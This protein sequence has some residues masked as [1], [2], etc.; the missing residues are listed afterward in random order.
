MLSLSNWDIMDIYGNIITSEEREKIIQ[1]VHELPVMKFQDD[2]THIVWNNPITIIQWETG[3]WKTTQVPQ[4][5]EKFW[6]IIT[7]EPRVI[8]AISVADRVSR[9]IMAKT[10]DRNYS[11]GMKVWY[12]TGQQVSSEH[13][14]KISFHTDGLEA[15]RQWISWIYSDV[16]I[17]DEVHWYSIPTEMIASNIRNYML[18]TK[19]KL[20]LV[21]MSAT[22][23]PYILQ[24]YFKQVSSDIPVIKIPGR[25]H[26]VEKHFL[27]NSDYVKTV[28]NHYKEK[29]N[30]LLFVE[31][32]KEIEWAIMSLKRQLWES[33]LIFPLHSELSIEEQVKLLK[34]EHDDPIIVVSTN[35]AEESITLEYIDAVVDIGKEKTLFVNNYGIDELRTIDIAK[36]NSIQKAGRAGRTHDGVYTFNSET[37]YESLRDFPIAPIEKE[38][39]DKYIL[40]SLIDTIDVLANFEKQFIHKPSSDLL[41]LSYNRLRSLWAIHTNGKITQL[42]IDILKFPVSVDN[43]IILIE[44]IQKWCSE[45]IIPMVAMLEKKWFVSKNWDWKNIK[46][47]GKTQWDLF[48]YLDLFQFIT[49]THISNGKRNLLKDFWVDENKLKLF[50][51]LDGKK[52]LFEVVNLDIIWIKTKK[53]QEIYNMIQLLKEKFE[54]VWYKIWKNTNIDDIKSCL[55]SWNLHNI[56]VY[57]EKNW[58]FFD[59]HKQIPINFIPG[60]ISLVELLNG[61]IYI[62]SPFIIWWS[63]DQNIIT[64]LIKI[65]EGIIKEYCDKMIDGDIREIFWHSNPNYKHSHISQWNIWEFNIDEISFNIPAELK[66]LKDKSKAKHYLAKNW[67]PYFLVN[68]NKNYIDFIKRSKLNP[69]IF[70]ELLK[71]IT[72]SKIQKINPDNLEKTIY[73]FQNDEEIFDEFI[74]S[75][76]INIKAFLDW[77]IKT[78]QDFASIEAKK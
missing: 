73:I 21:L 40:I 61:W 33:A 59:Y 38:K 39:L 78:T 17:L 75:D 52:M 49:S 44:S 64:N 48:S 29:K 36:S 71:K 66:I 4:I 51:E 55:V 7:T 13:T 57:N 2:I 11:L 70:C 58:G 41:K 10:W 42:W 50:Q 12:R 3:S 63:P 31:W 5:L 53:V 56:F 68:H 26:K 1:S 74:E 28:C 15:M 32:K 20:K 8:S 43:A 46:M 47:G 9:V 24:D 34:K 45:I 77:K 6:H 67:L 18:E 25:N 27:T 72:L 65:D 16:L 60:D 54:K 19:R 30:I 35:I 62:G 22:L 69:S 23:N 37:D 76:D 14:S